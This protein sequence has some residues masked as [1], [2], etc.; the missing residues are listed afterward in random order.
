[1]HSLSREKPGVTNGRDEHS[2]VVTALKSSLR[3][4]TAAFLALEWGEVRDTGLMFECRGVQVIQWAYDVDSMIQF[5]AQ[6]RCQGEHHSGALNRFRGKLRGNTVNEDTRG[7]RFAR[8][9]RVRWFA[10]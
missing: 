3:D 9:H 8:R 10:G 7:G 5:H 1:M 2:F 6:L 4:T